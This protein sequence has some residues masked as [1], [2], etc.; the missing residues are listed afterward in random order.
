MKQLAK[1]VL[2]SPIHL[3]KKILAQRLGISLDAARMLISRYKR[4]S[5]GR[6]LCPL[7]LNRLCEDH[8]GLVCDRCGFYEENP[9]PPRVIDQFHTVVSSVWGLGSKH[10]KINSIR[11]IYSNGYERFVKETLNE[12]EDLLKGF[13]LSV[14]ATDQLAALTK[15]YCRIYYGGRATDKTARFKS[16]LSALILAARSHPQI[17]RVIS[18]YLGLNIMNKTS[19]FLEV[20]G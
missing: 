3:D 1:L 11:E 12:L 10:E 20:K 6:Y 15:R 5:M 18:A 17:V 7:C 19:A 9:I 13:S 2:E 14:E 16:I 8:T 4:M